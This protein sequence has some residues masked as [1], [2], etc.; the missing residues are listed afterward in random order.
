MKQ[1]YRISLAVM[2][3]ALFALPPQAPAAQAADPTSAQRRAALEYLNAAASGSAQAVAFAIHPDELDRLRASLVERLREESKAGGSAL[4][5]RLFGP[6][7]TLQDVERMTSLTFFQTL[8]RGR[9]ALGQHRL[10][11][12]VKGLAAVAD[13]KTV[14]QVMVK[15]VQPKDRGTVDVVEVVSLMPYG[16]DWKATIPNHLQAQIDDLVAGRGPAAADAVGGAGTA[17]G[18]A[19]GSDGGAAGAG[20][21]TPEILGMLSNAEKAL[22]DNRCDDYYREYMSPTFRRTL[23]SKALTA[24]VNGCR[25]G[26]AQREVLIAALRIVKQLP[27]R[28]EYENTRAVYDVSGQGLPYDRFTL[29]RLDGR[30]YIAE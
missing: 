8:I 23:S 12:Q 22:L 16:K 28:Y 13:G 4:R 11:E 17:L 15:G 1:T 18:S 14:V 3:L 25:N 10:Y 24:L 30:W 21:G 9:L 27:P 29:E 6:V 7:T 2:V 20:T 5:A 19:D 26:I